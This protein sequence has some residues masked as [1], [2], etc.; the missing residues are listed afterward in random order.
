V[1]N[2]N[3]KAPEKET[4][5]STRLKDTSCL[6]I[7]RL[8]IVKMAILSKEATEPVVRILVS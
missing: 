1:Y 3:F 7:G 4:E 2:E 5:E 8:N 6:W